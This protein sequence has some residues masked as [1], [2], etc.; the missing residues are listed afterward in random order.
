MEFFPAK[1]VRTPGSSSVNAKG[2]ASRSL[3]GTPGSAR[4][5]GLHTN[6]HTLLSLYTE[7]PTGDIP[8]EEFEKLAL[9]RLR[10]GSGLSR[11]VRICL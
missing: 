9:D 11:V 10:G 7:L 1:S 5:G 6:K 4:D 3:G 2:F 8:L